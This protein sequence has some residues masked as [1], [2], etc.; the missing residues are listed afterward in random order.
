M[1]SQVAVEGMENSLEQHLSSCLEVLSQWR[2]SHSYS[3]HLLPLDVVGRLLTSPV[4]QAKE[5]IN[6]GATEGVLSREEVIKEICGLAARKF[7]FGALDNIVSLTSPMQSF[8][9]LMHQQ[10]YYSSSFFPKGWCRAL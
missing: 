9:S 1:S 8:P 2:A 10:T 3:D 7:A 5:S 6:S 4:Q